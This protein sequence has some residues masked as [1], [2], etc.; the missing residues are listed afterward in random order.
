[1]IVMLLLL[2][3]LLLMMRM[4][5]SERHGPPPPTQRLH[6]AARILQQ[7]Q[8]PKRPPKGGMNKPRPPTIICCTTPSQ[9]ASR[10]WAPTR[11]A[12]DDPYKHRQRQEVPSKLAR[13][14]TTLSACRGI[15]CGLLVRGRR[16]TPWTPPQQCSFWRGHPAMHCNTALASRP[17]WPRALGQPISL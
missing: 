1:M 9:R 12:S 11:P 7:K 3:L 17:S 14:D 4:I 8:P 5:R 13:F 10:N 6:W 16:T 2:L 15:G